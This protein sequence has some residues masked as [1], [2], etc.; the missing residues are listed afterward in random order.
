MES[1]GDSAV[2]RDLNNIKPICVTNMMYLKT[3]QILEHM[4]GVFTAD[5][6]VC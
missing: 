5:I 3:R 1:P 4:S 2:G 6:R